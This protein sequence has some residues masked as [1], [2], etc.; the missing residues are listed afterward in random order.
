M[1]AYLLYGEDEVDHY[2]G[3][4][5]PSRK[6]QMILDM[7][8]RTVIPA[9]QVAKIERLEEYVDAFVTVLDG[10]AYAAAVIAEMSERQL[11]YF[12]NYQLPLVN[13]SKPVILARLCAQV[14]LCLARGKHMVQE[15]WKTIDYFQVPVLDI[16][17]RVCQVNDE[18]LLRRKIALMNRAYAFWIGKNGTLS[19]PWEEFAKRIPL[20]RNEERNMGMWEEICSEMVN[21]GPDT[22]AYPNPLL[23]YNVRR[24]HPEMVPSLRLPSQYTVQIRTDHGLMTSV[25]TSNLP[26]AFVGMD[27]KVAKE[28]HW[29]GNI[30]RSALREFEID[31]TAY[32]VHSQLSLG[33]QAALVEPSVLID[34]DD[35]ELLIRQIVIDGVGILTPLMKK[36]RFLVQHIHISKDGGSMPDL[37]DE[38]E[39]HGSLFYIGDK[40]HVICSHAFGCFNPNFSIKVVYL[41]EARKDRVP[42]PK[43]LLGIYLY[44]ELE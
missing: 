25:A 26:I 27:L 21:G 39:T 28:A 36:E 3:P 31:L 30:L 13:V 43:F 35:G 34:S 24:R 37:Y 20:V 7:T 17:R 40:K 33:R 23:I 4:Q 8:A 2:E 15:F 29:L 16:F 12:V 44:R 1:K 18:L 42:K 19:I 22:N 9:Q 10:N 14:Y 32:F 38:P 5:S 11:D 6:E 41:A